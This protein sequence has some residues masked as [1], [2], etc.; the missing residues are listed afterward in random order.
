M[1][2]TGQGVLII[3]AGI[4][5]LCLAQGLRQAGVPVTVY[6]RDQAPDARLQ[7]YRLNI[8]P[9]SSRALHECLPAQLWDLLVRTAGDPGPGM[10][11]FTQRM[12]H[13]MREPGQSDPDP[14]KGAHAV[15]RAT[16]RR[17]LL[18]GLADVVAFGKEF[19]GY[20]RVTAR[21]ADGTTATG[22]VLVGADGVG[23]R[24][25]RQ[26][27]PRARV[28]TTGGRGIG[29]SSPWTSRPRAGCPNR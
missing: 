9:M 28:I 20:D 23:S 2:A 24:V 15:S 11:V 8:E 7:G 3:G 25:R 5:G 16:L 6:E 12:R 10:N 4:G 29:A 22:A 13:L 21:F 26:L 1:P 19:T 14:V 27:P 18:A 17:I